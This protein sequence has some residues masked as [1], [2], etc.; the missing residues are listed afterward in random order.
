VNTA[1]SDYIAAAKA[2]GATDSFLV[3]LLERNG[4]PRK[5]VYAAFATIYETPKRGAG[6][7]E[8]A[9]DAFLY[10]LSFG[11]LSTWAWALGSLFFTL[12][13]IRYRDPVF[14]QE[15]YLGRNLA[16]SGSMAALVV[17]FPIYLATMRILLRDI[18]RKPEK[19]ES[20]VR[21]WLT[22]IA[23]LISA[24]VVIGDLITTVDYFLRGEIT[25]RFVL[26]VLTV[27]VIAGGVFLYYLQPLEKPEA[28]S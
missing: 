19:L 18:S 23:L 17:S 3:E 1:L 14:T 24:S 27:L 15:P 11:T 2:R 12:I 7:A 25:T 16:I 13:D 4:W 6:F 28:Q 26:K 22:Y 10:L 5:E 9:R 8:S 20:G 21:K